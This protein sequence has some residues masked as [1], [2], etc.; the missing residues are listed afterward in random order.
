MIVK[1]IHCNVRLVPTWRLLWHRCAQLRF[2]FTANLRVPVSIRGKP[3]YEPLYPRS[4]AIVLKL[5]KAL[6]EFD[7]KEFASAIGSFFRLPFVMSRRDVEDCDK[8]FSRKTPIRIVGLVYVYFFPPIHMYARY[9]CTSP[10]PKFSRKVSEPRRDD[11]NRRR[12]TNVDRLSGGRPNA[13]LLFNSPPTCGWTERISRCDGR[14]CRVLKFKAFYLQRS[15]QTEGC[16]GKTAD[17]N[18]IWPRG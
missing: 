1:S 13:R 17:G 10:L 11:G 15:R 5:N 14:R 12:I 7:E 3:V 16:K 2:V 6:C 18:I 9:I 4:N 8:E